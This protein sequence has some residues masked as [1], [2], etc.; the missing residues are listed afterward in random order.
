MSR[1]RHRIQDF[2]IELMIYPELRSKIIKLA[3]L[4]FQILTNCAEDRPYLR[5]LQHQLAITY[6]I[7]ATTEKDQFQYE[8]EEE[9]A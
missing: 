5:D 8:E 6:N 4:I 3:D 9:I 1:I 2:D 7:I